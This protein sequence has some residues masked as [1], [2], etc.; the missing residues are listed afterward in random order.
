MRENVGNRL[1][2]WHKH[3]VLFFLLKKI[4]QFCRTSSLST[5]RRVINHGN[6]SCGF[7]LCILSVTSRVSMYKR[8][9]LHS[10]SFPH[11]SSC[12]IFI[13][14]IHIYVYMYVCIYICILIERCWYRHREN[15]DARVRSYVYV[16]IFSFD[17]YCTM[18]NL[19][20]GYYIM[21][22]LYWWTYTYIRSQLSLNKHTDRGH[23]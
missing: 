10:F 1:P 22:K 9:T 8:T 6:S 3:S 14:Y 20:L 7:C 11:S 17:K 4:T 16:R 5:H 21:D 19:F 18:I 2:S 12:Q 23:N 13:S 15:E